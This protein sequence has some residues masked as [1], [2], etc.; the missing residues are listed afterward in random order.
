MLSQMQRDS[1]KINVSGE[2]LSACSNLL[3]VKMFLPR[4]YV[5]RGE[6]LSLLCSGFSSVVHSCVD[7]VPIRF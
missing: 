3:S 5:L 7:Y 1:V 2:R 6:G 4:G